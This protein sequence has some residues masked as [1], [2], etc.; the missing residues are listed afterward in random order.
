LEKN[1]NLFSNNGQKYD[2][3]N[4][5]NETQNGV[6]FCKFYFYENGTLDN[7]YFPLNI[8]E[9]YISIIEDL[10]E[11]VTPKL[12]KSLYNNET[13]R[14]RLENGKEG[15]Y[16]NY[17]QIIRN[18]LLK[19]TVIYENKK[20][21]NIDNDDFTFE[22][23]E[24]N[25]RIVRTFDPLGDMTLLEME[26]EASFISSYSYDKNIKN[27][28][29]RLIEEE[30]EKK[31]DTNESFYNLGLNEFKMNVTSNMKLIKASL[32]PNLL[33]ILN[34]L[35]QKVKL[36]LYK[37]ESNTRLDTEEGNVTEEKTLNE[38]LIDLNDTN[39]TNNNN[40]SIINNIEVQL[41]NLAK[42]NINFANSY[43]SYNKVLGTSFLGLYVG[44]Q[45]NLYINRNNGLRQH[46]VTL[47][48]GSKQYTISTVNF[49]QYYNSGAK[50]TTKKVVDTKFGL[51]K[52]FSS[53][54][55]IIK[56]ELNLKCS[57]YHGVSID[58]I[59]GE[60]YTK[61]FADIDLAV[62]GSFG[63]D[64]IFVSFGASVVGH[65]AKGNS[66]IQANTLLNNNSNLAR[67]IFYRDMKSCSVDI[68]FYFS[69]WLV[70]YEKTFKE[71]INIFKGFSNYLN[72]YGYY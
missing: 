64:F 16:L 35:S 51:D 4:S 22:K 42:N 1:N 21:N 59:K 36:E 9:F 47:V 45:Q 26:G 48:I 27:N 69:V 34:D 12:S 38:S 14:R 29:L 66:Y 39:Y 49:Y 68:E 55:Y 33:Q 71:T 61:G 31:I 32:E 60:M 44:L 18:G 52:R 50:Y 58:V 25:S 56:A 62:V 13:E 65:L 30:N 6:P 5:I 15:K 63:P 53:F 37:N 19:K 10:I 24:I 17:E 23:N 3:K 46:Y 28:N 54:G 2:N 43:I 8:N 70:V 41:R 40:E 72:T 57:L 20:E 67:F 11:K 7:I